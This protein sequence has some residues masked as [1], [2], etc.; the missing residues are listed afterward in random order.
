MKASVFFENMMRERSEGRAVGIYSVCS[1]HPMVI[2][3]AMQQ[4]AQDAMPVLIEATSNQ[5][6]Q[7][8]GYT[9]MKPDDFKAF[10]Y[11]I[12]EDCGFPLQDILL[13]GDHLGPFVWR[14][15]DE[16]Q[17]M[18]LAEDLVTAYVRAGFSKIHLDTSMWL[19]DDD[20]SRPLSDEIIARRGAR[21]CAAAERARVDED[22]VYVIGSEVPAPGGPAQETDTVTP[23]TPEAFL[24]SYKTFSEV[25][26]QHHLQDAFRRVVAFVVQPGVEFTDSEVFDYDCQVAKSLCAALKDLPEPLVF[27]GHSTDYQTP[28]ALRNL[29]QDGVAILKVGPALTFTLRQGLMALENIERELAILYGIEPSRFTEKLTGAMLED[30]SNWRKYYDGEAE[31]LQLQLRYSLLD[32]SRYY[33]PEPAVQAAVDRLISNLDKTGIP[34]ALLSQ[35][36]QQQFDRVRSGE[37]TDAPLDLLADGIRHCLAGYSAA[38]RN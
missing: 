5:V 36:M 19:A 27:E 16:E 26:T 34:M 1:A 24:S 35:Y 3:A 20:R 15:R 17:A 11:G 10:V 37:I 7:F 18:S 38:V 32:R 23:T 30:D 25:F 28:G 29:V 21:L 8:G 33:L 14:D 22:L 9:G 12:A 6:N 4:S 2:R 31:R 13:G